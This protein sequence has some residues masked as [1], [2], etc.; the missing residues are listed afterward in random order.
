MAFGVTA[1]CAA[2]CGQGANSAILLQQVFGIAPPAQGGGAN[3]LSRLDVDPA[4]LSESA[5]RSAAALQDLERAGL[6]Y[7]PGF[8]PSL[9]LIVLLG[10]LPMQ[11]SARTPKGEKVLR[12]YHVAAP[13][14]TLEVEQHTRAGHPL[15]DWAFEFPW[16]SVC[17]RS[18]HGC[19]AT[20]FGR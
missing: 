4:R 1:T 12:K 6:V 19:C 15:T 5:E 16:D 2:S 13:L 10:L 3:P 20:L 14:W 17:Q 18:A 8:V 9:D 11:F 7:D